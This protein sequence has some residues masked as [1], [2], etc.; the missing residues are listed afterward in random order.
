MLRNFI[1]A[2][3]LGVTIAQDFSTMSDDEQAAFM[4]MSDEEQEA[5]A[6]QQF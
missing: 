2:L 6:M 1:A 4:N 3:L 5:W